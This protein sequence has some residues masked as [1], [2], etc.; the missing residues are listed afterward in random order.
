MLRN[1]AAVVAGFFAAGIV[2]M[3]CE[4][5]NSQ[6]FPFPAGMDVNDIDQ[7]RQFAAAMPR[8]ALILVLVGWIVGSTSGGFIATK[9]ATA[10]SPVPALIV[11][12]LLTALGGLN[13]WMI[14]N[15]LWFHVGSLP[16]FILFAMIGEYLA[17]R[18]ATA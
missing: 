14:Q 18:R 11:G 16:L 7:V 10:S 13:A 2:M 1:V 9:I 12:V 6:I 3:I 4:Y 5:S 8:Q 15:P 17:R